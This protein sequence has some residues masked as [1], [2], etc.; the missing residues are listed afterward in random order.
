VN[1]ASFVILSPW[2]CAFFETPRYGGSSVRGR[3]MRG[4]SHMALAAALDTAR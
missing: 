3:D 2:R 4:P 1:A